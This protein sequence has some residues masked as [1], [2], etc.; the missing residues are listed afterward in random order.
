MAFRQGLW[1]EPVWTGKGG[2]VPRHKHRGWWPLTVAHGCVERARA[3][4]LTYGSTSDYLRGLTQVIC[5]FMPPF[6]HMSNDDII[7]TP[8]WVVERLN[9]TGELPPAQCWAEF[10]FPPTMFLLCWALTSGWPSQACVPWPLLCG[11]RPTLPRS[12]KLKKTLATRCREVSIPFF[13]KHR[14]AG[15]KPEWAKEWL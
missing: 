9:H 8:H 14:F 15:G 1:T 5:V 2:S 3:L 4:G 12:Q 7:P 6:S 10:C 13:A 11:W